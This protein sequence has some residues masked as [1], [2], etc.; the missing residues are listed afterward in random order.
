M[1]DDTQ[2]LYPYS[3]L[4]NVQASPLKRVPSSA[5]ATVYITLGKDIVNAFSF[6]ASQT[7][8]VL[9]SLEAYQPF[10]LPGGSVLIQIAMQK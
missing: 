10:P 1:G 9:L 4:T 8:E 2:K 3:S 5:N 6:S 7:L